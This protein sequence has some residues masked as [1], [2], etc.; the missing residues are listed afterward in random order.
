MSGKEAMWKPFRRKTR[1]D[2]TLRLVLAGA[3]L[4]FGIVIF[5]QGGSVF[6]LLEHALVAAI[7]L[8]I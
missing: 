6:W 3:Y 2:G 4:A 7:V 1:A 8:A 5:L